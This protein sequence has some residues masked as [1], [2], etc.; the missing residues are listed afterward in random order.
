M[1]ILIVIGAVTTFLG[2]AGLGYCIREAMRI[3]TGGM[4]PEESKVKLR[5][6]VAVNMAAVGVAFLGL[7]MVV[8]GVIL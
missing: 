2:I 7:A 3:R 1:T 8:A 5:G 6:L 4:S